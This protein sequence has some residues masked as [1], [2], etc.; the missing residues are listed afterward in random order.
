MTGEERRQH[1]KGCTRVAKWPLTIAVSHSP[2]S[3]NRGY[4]ALTGLFATAP[5]RRGRRRDTTR[6]ECDARK[7]SENK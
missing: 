1:C 6:F 4:Y 2:V 5:G 7:T 3:A